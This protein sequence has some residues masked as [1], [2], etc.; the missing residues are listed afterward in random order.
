M[1]LADRDDDRRS[2]QPEELMLGWIRHR[3]VTHV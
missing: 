1:I 2:A 3:L